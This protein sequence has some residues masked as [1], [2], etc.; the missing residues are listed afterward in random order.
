MILA[1][2]LTHFSFSKLSSVDCVVALSCH[3][4]WLVRIECFLLLPVWCLYKA[5]QLPFL[6]REFSFLHFR[7]LSACSSFTRVSFLNEPPDWANNAPFLEL[8]SHH[9]RLHVVL[10]WTKQPTNCLYWKKIQFSQELH[11]QLP[12]TFPNC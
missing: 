12:N 10:F 8:F 3:F 6:T 7:T 4:L 5:W 2:M 9:H 1:Y 11:A